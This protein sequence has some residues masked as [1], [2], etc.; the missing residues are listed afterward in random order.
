MSFSWPRKFSQPRQRALCQ[1]AKNGH[2]ECV[3]ALLADRRVSLSQPDGGALTAAASSGQDAVVGLLLEHEAVDLR[4]GKAALWAAIDGCHASVV[5]LLLSHK[6]LIPLSNDA[7]AGA[8][9][10]GNIRMVDL[11]LQRPDVNVAA[12][13]HWALRQA[14]SAAR[15]E[16]VARLLAEPRVRPAEAIAAGLSHEAS[17]TAIREIEC[18]PPTVLEQ[19]LSDPRLDCT[20]DFVWDTLDGCITA[21]LK[22]YAAELRSRIDSAMELQR[23]RYL[24][25][26]SFITAATIWENYLDPPPHVLKWIDNKTLDE[27]EAEGWVDDN[28][29]GG[30]ADIPEWIPPQ[31]SW[32]TVE[33]C[34][35]VLMQ[36]ALLRRRMETFSQWRHWEHFSESYALRVALC[37]L[38]WR[39][40]MR[41]ILARER[42]FEED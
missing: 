8:A 14:V 2:L 36:P 4:A 31:P 15:Q 16:V 21:E 26:R 25:R 42:A 41:V 22:A 19:L 38:T 10:A 34:S 17:C 12:Y 9:H 23:E 28:D 20:S 6:P 24:E 1:A 35:L 37:R 40:R 30:A 5:A 11:L 3:R 39:R 18:S 27:G 32:Q 29:D 7:L 33:R 13:S